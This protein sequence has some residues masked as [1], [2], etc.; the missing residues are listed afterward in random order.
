[1]IKLFK[2]LTKKEWLFVGI[3]LLFIIAQVWL[4]LKLP[5][6]MSEITMLVQ[7]EGST[8]SEILTAGGKMLTCALGSLVG[9]VIV[10]AL[11]A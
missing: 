8:M 5:D 7:I 2:N 3:S 6:Y 9:S 4:D 10:A 11:A 1:M